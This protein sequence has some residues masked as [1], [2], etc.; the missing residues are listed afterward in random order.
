MKSTERPY[1]EIMINSR[2]LEVPRCSYQR[3]LNPARV[4]RIAAEFDEHIANEPKVS[5]R[6]GHY[7]V[8]DGQ[9]TIAARKYRNNGRDLP[10]RCKVYRGMTESEEALLFAQQTGASAILGAG[11]KIRAEIY[12][13]DPEAISFM[14]TTESAG[15][16]LDYGQARGKARIGCIATALNEF[17][18]VGKERYKEAM[19]IIMKAWDGHPDSMRSETII[20][21]TRFVDLYHKEYDPD[22]L[23]KRLKKSDPV[24]IYREGHAMCSN[25]PG[26]KK[27]LYQVLSIYN[28]TSKKYAL[29][30]KF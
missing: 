28:G 24:T 3:E 22:R 10:V 18:K 17:R 1:Q 12:G 9:H 5:L 15:I 25:M 27:Y 11:A 6:D 8:F 7:Y 20:G 16:V 29:P 23:V 2:F 19:D 4:Q 21:I 30:M 26:H 13:G 14:K